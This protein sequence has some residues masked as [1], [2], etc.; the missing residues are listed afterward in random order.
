MYTWGFIYFFVCELFMKPQIYMWCHAPQTY[1]NEGSIKRAHK[2]TIVKLFMLYR[3]I[4]YSTRI[5]S[6]DTMLVIMAMFKYQLIWDRTLE[7]MLRLQML[8]AK[9][10][11]YL[12]HRYFSHTL[13]RHST[14]LESSW[15]QRPSSH[16]QY[17]GYWWRGDAWG[18]A[19]S[20]HDIVLIQWDRAVSIFFEKLQRTL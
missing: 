17:H 5:R 9:I 7:I 4:T 8:W 16:S 3:I 19:I 11:I 14:L 13:H 18:Q 10:N 2:Q 12:Y 1:L 15:S 20:R 6:D